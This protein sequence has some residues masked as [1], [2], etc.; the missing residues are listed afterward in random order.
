MPVH[1][2]IS[3]EIPTSLGS[4]AFGSSSHLQRH[5]T[6][7]WQLQECYT[8]QVQGLLPP[9]STNPQAYLV[10]DVPRELWPL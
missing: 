1:Y 2:T 8:D 4:V 3:N 6:H 5:R 7:Q 9:S 10:G